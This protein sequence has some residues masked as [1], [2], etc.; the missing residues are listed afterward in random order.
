MSYI[1]RFSLTQAIK[2][3]DF[4]RSLVATQDNLLNCKKWLFIDLL[5]C[6]ILA[7]LRIPRLRYSKAVVLLQIAMLW[8]LDGLM[9][10]G[11]SLNMVGRPGGRG[12]PLPGFSGALNL[13][14]NSS[15]L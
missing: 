12:A 10:G 14:L 11:I 5:Y 2:L 1:S 8:F 3:L 13:T 6:V 4:G 7:Q 15:P 9:F